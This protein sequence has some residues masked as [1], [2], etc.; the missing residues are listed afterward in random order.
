MS[1]TVD[2][3][4]SVTT[5]RSPSATPV[6]SSRTTDERRARAARWL[7]ATLTL[8]AIVTAAW[9]VAVIAWS[10]TLEASLSIPAAACVAVGLVSLV[11]AV[12]FAWFRARPEPR[13][14]HGS[15]AGVGDVLFGLALLIAAVAAPDV[16]TTGRWLI[17]LSGLVVLDVGVVELWLT[18]R[19][20]R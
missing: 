9:A 2:R 5:D 14:E 10:G 15:L 19:M 7:R 18:R 8:N 6:P 20:V 4:P 1:A 11:A 17:G 13:A 3:S 16:S 12:A